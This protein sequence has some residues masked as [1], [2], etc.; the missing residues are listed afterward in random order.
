MTDTTNST[1][2]NI[3]LLS[4]DCWRGDHIGLQQGSACAT[5]NIDNFAS[6]GTW[7]SDSYT[8]G[9]WTKIA[10]TALFSSTY[11][12]QYNFAQGRLDEQR[13]LLAEALQEA[14]YK[15]IG[16]TSNPVCGAAQGFHRGF[17]HFADIRPTI[18]T[19]LADRIFSFRGSWRLLKNRL[20]RR[21]LSFIRLHPTPPQP[22]CSADEVIEH[23]LP[24]LAQDHDAPLF[25]WLHFMDLLWPYQSRHRPL[26]TEEKE[27]VWKDRLHWGNQRRR[28]GRHNPGQIRADRWK[29]LYREEVEQMDQCFGRLFDALYGMRGWES[30]HV[31]LTSDHGEEFFEHGTWAHSWNQLHKEGAH[32]P[33][34][35]RQ[36][37]TGQPTEITTP[38][39]HLDIAPTILDL[40]GI[41][42]PEA[43][44]GQSLIGRLKGEQCSDEAPVY[45][46]MHG[47]GGSTLYRLSITYDGYRYI[48]DGD[49]DCC[50]LF[51]LATDP[52]ERHDLYNK[53]GIVSRRFDRLRLSHVSKGVVNILKSGEGVVGEDI[54][55]DL[56]ADPKVVERLRALGYLD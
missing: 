27:Q 2:P 24:W 4:V 26:T 41:E 12:S 53:D 33:L 54:L 47:H 36:A 38:T 28:K 32:V 44:Q 9:G 56:D 10:M 8:C 3:I 16:V 48:Y 13:P 34:I 7:F 51:E 42:K 15:T 37:G 31:V 35:I 30:T 25:L 46:E 1:R 21:F 11:S 18:E 43:M 50:Y 20:L 17:D 22:A 49:R 52:D 19:S 23:G 6:N 55:Y 40:A 45:S 39:S 14:G 5:P 29:S